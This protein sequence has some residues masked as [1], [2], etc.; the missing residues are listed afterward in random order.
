MVQYLGAGQS[1]KLAPPV[2]AFENQHFKLLIGANYANTFS[3]D[4]MA[5]TKKS[6]RE[7]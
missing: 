2:A 3:P 6:I 5:G 1:G 7:L 4:Q